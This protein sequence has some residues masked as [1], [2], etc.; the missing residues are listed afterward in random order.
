[1]LSDLRVHITQLQG[2]IPW[3]VVDTYSKIYQIYFS[4]DADEMPQG[5]LRIRRF[6][7]LTRKLRAEAGLPELFDEDDLPDPIYDPNYVHVLSEKQE[8][9]L[10]HRESQHPVPHLSLTLFE[11]QKQFA[12]SQTWYRPHGTPTHRVS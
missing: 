9:E 10:H 3:R 11:E 12:K 7:S 6:K 2:L 8:M 4:G 5:I 1:M